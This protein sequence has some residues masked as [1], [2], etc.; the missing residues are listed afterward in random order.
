MALRDRA[1]RRGVA[2]CRRSLS[3]LR[4]QRPSLPPVSELLGRFDTELPDVVEQV[5][6]KH[7]AI[8]RLQPGRRVRTSADAPSD[9]GPGADR[10]ELF[11]AVHA[12]IDAA[13][14][15]AP[16]LVVIEDTHWADQS[17]R[18]LLGFLF[19]RTFTHQVALV[20]SYRSDDLHRRH[21]LRRQV[22]EWSRLQTV[23]RLALSPLPDDAVRKLI[24]ELPELLG[25]R[26]LAEI[27]GR[28]EGNAFFVEELVASGAG[29]WVP[30]D[31]ASLLL[32]RLDRLSDEARQVVRI[33]SVAGRKV[34]HRLLE[35]PPASP[36]RT[37]TPASAGRRDQRPRRRL[38][39]RLLLPARPDPR[40]H[41]RRPAARR[42]G[43]AARPVRRSP[44]RRRRSTA[45]PPRW[46]VTP[47]A[48]TDFDRAAT[49][50]IEA[51]DEA[52]SVGGPDE[53][54]RHYEHGARA[55]RGLR[56]APSA[57]DLDVTKVGRQGRR[58]P[59]RGR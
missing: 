30:D 20:A 46:P 45:R 12:L 43:P 39:R 41:L 22:A 58:R 5:S 27:I 49:A 25:E 38:Q 55:A 16:L 3:R 1:Q 35:A 57:V 33:A 19:T 51:G 15:A 53:A 8:G 54:A 29:A 26:G 21:P 17:T 44:R 2:G 14:E 9:G 24:A 23:D 42:A 59:Q 56:P 18:D 6:A 13:A 52:V 48:A 11:E 4:R 31:L 32:V 36:T 10:G 34:T 47:A 28:A 37:S 40:G 50:G 7:P